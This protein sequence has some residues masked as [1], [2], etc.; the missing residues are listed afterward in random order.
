[1]DLVLENKLLLF[2]SWDTAHAKKIYIRPGKAFYRM[3]TGAAICRLPIAT[4]SVDVILRN[5]WR[6]KKMSFQLKRVAVDDQTI[7]YID[8]H[9]MSGLTFTIE[10]IEVGFTT[11]YFKAHRLQLQ[12]PLAAEVPARSITINH[13]QLND[14]AS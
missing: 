9:L 4:Q 3:A 1:M 13:L 5:S 12:M 11:P 8:A 7:R 10:R 2:I 6:S 14:Y